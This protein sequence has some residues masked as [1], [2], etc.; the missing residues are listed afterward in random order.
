MTQKYMISD[1]DL[2]TLY[3]ELESCPDVENIL[4]TKYNIEGV[5]ELPQ[6]RFQDALEWIQYIKKHRF[7]REG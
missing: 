3:K 1:H 6:V 7:N 5:D 2:A 4:C